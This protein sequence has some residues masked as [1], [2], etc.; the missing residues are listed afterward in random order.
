MKQNFVLAV[1]TAISFSSIAQEIPAGIVKDFTIEKL[2]PS[3][4]VKNQ[5]MTGTCWSFST[6]ALVESQLIKNNIGSLDL[7]EMFTVRNIYIEKAK[8][9]LG[10]QGKAQFGEGSL[11]HDVIRAMDKYGA[12][13]E[14]AYSGLTEGKTTHNHSGLEKELKTYL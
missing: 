8:N 3:T 11:G 14:Q 10:R 9:Y 6:T 1:F 4:P 13:P 5:A 12:V 2:N 7:S